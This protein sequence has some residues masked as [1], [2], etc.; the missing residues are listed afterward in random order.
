MNQPTH[1]K[2][3]DFSQTSA[4][5]AYQN[6]EIDLGELIK[7]I[8]ATRGLVFLSVFVAAALYIAFTAFS[9]ASK[10]G[11]VRYSQVFDLTFDGVQKGQFPNGSPFTMTEMTSPAVLNAVFRQHNLGENGLKLDEFRRAVSIEPFS[12]ETP[13]I[14][15]RFESQITKNMSAAELA[16]LQTG[17][18]NEL[19]QAQKGAVRISLTFEKNALPSALAQQVLLD[20]VETWAVSTIQNDGVLQLD[21]PMYTA[22]IFD[23]ERFE[24]LD[25]L[26]GIELLLDNI[27]LVEGNIEKLK[28]QPNAANVVDTETGFNLEDLNKT[29]SDIKQYDLRQLMDPIKEL[30]LTRNKEVVELYYNRQLSELSLE[31]QF[32]VQ[33]SELTAR[34]LQGFN[35]SGQDITQG[36]SS[37]QSAMP[38]L[39]DAFLDRLVELSQQSG[40][41]EFRQK[42][43]QQV[44]EYQN[45]ALTIEQRIE[46]IKLV[47]S[48]LQSNVG[49]A[50]KLRSVYLEQV[51]QSLPKVL[52]E[53]RNYTKVIGR[54]HQQLGK[55]ASGSTGQLALPQGGS[56][57]VAE[58]SPITK[59]NI[60]ILIAL[61]IGVGFMAMLVGLMRQMGRKA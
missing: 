18:K 16:E 42:L 39:G 37:S 13:F 3:A 58:A 38:Q 27:E 20:I 55:Q 61:C 47:L 23:E 34:V 49:D 57:E 33:R 30:G 28:E 5:Y 15:Q 35:S 53:L 31:K 14:K 4:P 19:S 10:A 36:Q 44:L 6:D 60:L 25:Y 52:A 2:D 26:I 46:E 11:F 1:A 59:K 17:L 12:P 7:K 21:I 29:I 54:M 8:W 9:Y 43:T 50:A 48:A 41:Q 22:K 51:K 40:E 32:W 56:F 24:G 45:K